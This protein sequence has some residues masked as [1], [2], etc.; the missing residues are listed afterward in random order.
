MKAASMQLGGTTPGAVA[1]MPCTLCP[2]PAC[3]HSL[4]KKV[5][6]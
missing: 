4:A 2:H 3:R 5:S 1:G 6:D